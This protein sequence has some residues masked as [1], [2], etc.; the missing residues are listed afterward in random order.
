MAGIKTIPDSQPGVRNKS[1]LHPDRDEGHDR[2]IMVVTPVGWIAQV[3]AEDH[4][5]T[6]AQEPETKSRQQIDCR[7]NLPQERAAQGG[8]RYDDVPHQV[9]QADQDHHGQQGHHAPPQ[10]EEL[11]D[12]GHWIHKINS[13]N[14]PDHGRRL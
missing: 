3:L 5:I 6:R 10:T 8:N 11:N 7:R 2:L 14:E 12:T 9:I 13:G 4:K 1:C